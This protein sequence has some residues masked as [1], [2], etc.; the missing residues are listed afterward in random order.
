VAFLIEPYDKGMPADTEPFSLYVHIPYCIS[1]C[2]YCDFNSHVVP[3]IPEASYTEA[4]IDELKHYAPIDQWRA[5][6]VQTIFFGGGTPSTFQ[7][8]SIG[9]LIEK[10]A[11]LFAID[12]YCE[13]TLEA[14]PGTVDRKNFAGYRAA[15]VN[16]ISV[17]VQSFQPHLLK[18][19]GRVHSAD[20]AVRALQV[21]GDAGFE[22][23]NL[24]LIY[25]NPGQSLEDLEADLDTALSF[26][27]PHLSAYNLTIEEGTPFHH[28]HR[29]G[30]FKLL[31]EE[32]EIAMVELIEQ[33]LREA[34]LQRYEISN[35]A[36]PGFHSRHNV[37]YWQSG[38]YLGVGAGAH[39]YKSGAAHGIYGRRWWNEKSP[40]RYM[41]RIK[42][43]GQAV[44]ATEESEFAKAAGE[45][46]F[47]GLRLTEGVSLR[48]FSLRFGKNV[49]E[50]YPQISGW[51]S[52]DLMEIEG[53]R[54]RLSHRGLL[55][56]NSIFVHFV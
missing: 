55:V 41:N 28:E 10:T 54:L 1:K 20:E 51:V 18:F 6:P 34:G 7:P 33:R 3:E 31:S 30:K 53:D 29:C 15:G 2:P 56:A 50:L 40:A 48:A 43:S 49:L 23:F 21:I 4:L 24:D 9:L 39:S 44:T 42:E 17:G 27:S 46:M 47:S 8:S 12:P 13:I 11:A 16:R 5:R 36:R 26:Q 38:D 52:E 45:Y 25:A 22:N 35:Y 37:N 32:E 19:L 14:N